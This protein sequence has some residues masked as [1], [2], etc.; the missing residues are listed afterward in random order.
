MKTA[1]AIYSLEAEQSFVAA[2]LSQT[3]A[4]T[5]FDAAILRNIQASDFYIPLHQA[6]FQSFASLSQSRAS[7]PNL[8]LLLEHLRAHYPINDSEKRAIAALSTHPYS[9]DNLPAHL[10]LIFEKSQAR[11]LEKNIGRVLEK[12]PYVGGKYDIQEVLSELGSLTSPSQFKIKEPELLQ[13]TKLGLT[14]LVEA[15]E[16]AEK[17][18]LVGVQSGIRDLDQALSPGLMPGD[19][20]LVAGRPSMGKTAFGL[21]IACAAAN[22]DINPHEKGEKVTAVFSLEMSTLQLTMR[23]IANLGGINH[24]YLRRGDLNDDE[25]ARLTR[26]IQKYQDL[27]LAVDSE[28]GL[29]PGLLRAKLKMLEARTG[30]KVGLI[31]IDYIQLMK[32]DDE[33]GR[34]GREKEIGSISRSLKEIA[35]EFNAPMIALSQLNRELERR[36]DKRPVLSDLR[37]SGTLEQDSDVVIMLYRDEY[38]NPDSQLKGTAEIIIRK[39]RNGSVG[40]VMADFNGQFQRFTSR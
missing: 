23:N 15:L 20:I 37:E 13:G 2:L 12:V 27:D 16:S 9:I 32:A 34:E 39:Y 35:K 7:L 26:A 24:D 14:L 31:L 3:D 22:S 6:I 25:Y 17:G 29:T 38:Y 28:V 1:P 8:P 5:A 36:Q 10:D 4:T 30:K 33:S 18:D 40:T 19:L 11:L 21:N